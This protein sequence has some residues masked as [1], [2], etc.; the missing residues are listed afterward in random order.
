MTLAHPRRSNRRLSAGLGAILALMVVTALVVAGCGS[1]SKAAA[2]AS[3]TGRTAQV[4]ATVRL[5]NLIDSV[6]G[7]VQLTSTTGKVTGTIQVAGQNASQVAAG[8]S[9]TLAFFKLPAGVSPG[10]FGSGSARPSTAPSAGSGGQGSGYGQ[11]YFGSGNGSSGGQGFF[12]QGGQG[13]QGV[14]RGGKTAQAQ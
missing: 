1:S 11:G 9:V 5:G 6:T 10:A 7:R 2:A 13:G 4:L 12:G 3:T 14:L 8:Q